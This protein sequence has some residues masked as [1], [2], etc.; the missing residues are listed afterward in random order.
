MKRRVI[1][2]FGSFN[3]IHRGH[4]ALAEYAIERDLCDEV[5]MIVSPQNPLKN[6]SDLA[7]ELERFTMA[8]L[9]CGVSKYPDRIKPS[10]IE[11]ML[12][13]PSYTINTLRHLSSEYGSVMEFS[14]LM[15]GDLIEQLDRW[16]EYEEILNNYPIYVYPRRGES[17]EKYR[18]RVTVL[19]D[20]PL[21]DVSST[22]IRRSLMRGEDVSKLIT[23]EVIKHIKEQGFWSEE[24]YIDILNSK[25][26]ADPQSIEQLLERAKWFYRRNRWGEALNDFNRVLDIEP[27]NRE[28]LEMVKMTSQILE[29]RYK[30]IYNP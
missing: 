29:F 15:G 26:E 2:Y 14:I 24:G 18:D 27:N 11:F 3:P 17:I 8:E 7:P 21:F 25:I 10:V 30:D 12:E 22:E 6:S 28:A 23:E 9:A 5:I 16:R 4:T 1:L 19:E 13:R 20:A